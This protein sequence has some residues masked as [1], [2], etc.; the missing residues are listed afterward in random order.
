MY[1]AFQQ[2][3]EQLKHTSIT[4]MAAVETAVADS[5]KAVFHRDWM[6]AESVMDNDEAINALQYD[7]DASCLKLLALEQPYARDL[8]FI[9]G[10]KNAASQLE[11]IGD[12]AVNIAERAILLSQHGELPLSPEVWEL[13]DNATAMFRKAIKAMNAGD[14]DLAREVCAMNARGHVLYLKVFS[15]YINYMIE[16]SR[17][18]QRA[19]HLMFLSRSLERVGDRATNLAEITVFIATGEDIRQECGR[20]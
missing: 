8:R 15:H 1:T 9:L 20:Y 18:V 4:M 3:L 13:A 7:I 11:R 2:E 16:E 17:A 5:I 19:V 12:E 10:T 6:A 14:A